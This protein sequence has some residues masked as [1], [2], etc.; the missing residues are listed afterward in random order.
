MK[1]RNI[2]NKEY[3]TETC[4]KGENNSEIHREETLYPKFQKKLHVISKR[5]L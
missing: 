5:L 1:K 4:Y 3:F 2:Q